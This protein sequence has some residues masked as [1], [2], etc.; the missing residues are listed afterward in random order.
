VQQFSGGDKMF[1]KSFKRIFFDNYQKPIYET[2]KIKKNEILGPVCIATQIFISYIT[3][4]FL[5][6]LFINA[7][8]PSVSAL[9]INVYDKGT[10]YIIWNWSHI[11]EENKYIS[12]DG[13][14]ITNFDNSS[15]KY[16]IYDLQPNTKHFIQIQ[17]DDNSYEN[18][19]LT[20]PLTITETNQER[21]FNFVM[22]YIFIILVIILIIV[23]TKIPYI[24]IIAFILALIN[25][26]LVLPNGI[27]FDDIIFFALM[28]AAAS[29]TAISIKR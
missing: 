8:S 23:A 22:K 29:V 4:I 18:I 13:K 11:S 10:D 16:G 3:L 1:Y 20:L 12:I 28:L 6:A 2:Y 21:F 5:I 19:T 25:L 26:L 27:F 7:F 17:I 14:L 15:S 9:D 24:G